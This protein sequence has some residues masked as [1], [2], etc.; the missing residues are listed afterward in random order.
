MNISVAYQDI[1]QKIWNHPVHIIDDEGKMNP[2][3][4]IPFCQLGGGN[5]SLTGVMTHHSSFHVP[6]CNSFQAKILDNQLCYEVDFDKFKNQ[7][8]IERNLKLGFQFWMDYNEDRQL[9]M[10]DY[11]TD[12][13]IDGSDHEN[14]AFI[15][16]NTI[17]EFVCHKIEIVLY[18]S[19]L[20]ASEAFWRR[21]V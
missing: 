10:H 12:A 3:S 21:E 7:F 11:A 6:V 20:R 8:S 13:T 15:Y 18:F 14:G 17:G 19:I 16:I 1:I 4:F 5:M 2:S 9:Q